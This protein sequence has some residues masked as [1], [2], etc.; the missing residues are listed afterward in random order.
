MNPVAKKLQQTTRKV[1]KNIQ[2]ID[3]NKYEMKMKKLH[4]VIKL[5][6]Y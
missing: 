5:F 3:K 4:A 1:C 6:T 2:F